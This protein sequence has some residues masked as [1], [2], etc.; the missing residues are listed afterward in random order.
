MYQLWPNMT[1]STHEFKVNSN[2][3]DIAVNGPIVAKHDYVEILIHVQFAKSKHCCKWTNVAKHEYVNIR[4]QVQST[5]SRYRC[6]FNNCGQTRLCHQTNSSSNEIMQTL[7]QM[8][9]MWPNMSTSTFVCKFNSNKVD[10]TDKIRIVAKHE[11]VNTRI[12]GQF[13]QSRHCCKCTNYGQTR[14]CRNSNSSSIRKK[15]TL[16]LMGQC[17]QT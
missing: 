15:Q 6:L 13:K 17:G 16:L 12:Q 1:M 3:A 4:M 11:Y 9:Q 10:I 5:Q 8:C 2:K 14:L 7:L